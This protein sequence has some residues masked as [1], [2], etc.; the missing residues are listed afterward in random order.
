[1]ISV[2]IDASFAESRV[3]VLALEIAEDI[4]PP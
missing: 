4:I 1:L 2:E 3:I